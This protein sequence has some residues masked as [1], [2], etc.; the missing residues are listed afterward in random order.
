MMETRREFDYRIEL[1]SGNTT[2]GGPR[3]AE[4]ITKQLQ[5]ER[6]TNLSA[7]NE[8]IDSKK[9]TYGDMKELSTEDAS[10]TRAVVARGHDLYIDRS[11]IR[12]GQQ[13]ECP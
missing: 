4:I 6:C 10:L 1:S 7:P 12:Y 8:R 9:L 2:E 5:L 11:D 13:D 3:H